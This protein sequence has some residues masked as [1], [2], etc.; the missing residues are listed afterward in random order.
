MG[1][2]SLPPYI[3]GRFALGR[4]CRPTPEVGPNKGP[5][6]ELESLVMVSL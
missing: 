2:P 3:T 6:V 1:P 4:S 5:L